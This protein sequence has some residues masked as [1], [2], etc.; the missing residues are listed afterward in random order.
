VATWNV[1]GRFGDWSARHNGLLSEVSSISPD[2]LCLQESWETD[3]ERQADL[4]GEALGL[5]HR[6][7]AAD[8]SW[9]GWRSG[10]TVL[11]RWPI[12]RREITRL[13]GG[14]DANGMAMFALLDGL[15]Q[16]PVD[17]LVFYDAWQT[18]GGAGDG[19]SWDN[20]NPLAA[21]C[22]LPNQRLDYI[23]TAWPRRGGLGHPLS[24]RL[25]GTNAA[26]ETPI[27]DHYGVY[28][29]LRY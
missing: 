4:V 26:G 19:Y 24:C 2:I 27:S 8:W 16:P 28:A 3:D 22:L 23:F 6:Y 5:R 17:G 25:L 13:R 12:T 15:S 14:A 10:A 18:A 9:D 29:D 7:S 20:A 21:V 11:S 1:W